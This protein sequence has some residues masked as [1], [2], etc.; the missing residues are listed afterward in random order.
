VLWAAPRRDEGLVA[1]LRRLPVVGA[2]VP[3]PRSLEQ[4]EVITYRVQLHL[5]LAWCPSPACIVGT[6]VDYTTP[7]P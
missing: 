5:V 1:L 2:L 7:S 6:L 4:G 3:G